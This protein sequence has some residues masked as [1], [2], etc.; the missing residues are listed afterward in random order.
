LTPVDYGF[1]AAI[2]LA[3]YTSGMI[4]LKGLTPVDLVGHEA[5]ANGAVL[6]S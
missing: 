3:N 6:I 2:T 4:L 1:A 5:A